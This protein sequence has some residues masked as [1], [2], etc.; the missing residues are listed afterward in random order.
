MAIREFYLLLRVNIIGTKS[1]GLL[2]MLVNEHSLFTIMGW[3]P[4]TD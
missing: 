1:V 4:A 2:K 3:M